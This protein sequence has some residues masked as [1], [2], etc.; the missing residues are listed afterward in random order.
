[1]TCKTKCEIKKIEFLTTSTLKNTAMFG[2]TF[3]YAGQPFSFSRDLSFK[4][5][6]E[7]SNIQGIQKQ[8]CIVLTPCAYQ[9]CR[10][11]HQYKPI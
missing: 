5:G 10:S 11:L 2:L 7:C 9:I 8:H 3:L 6:R 4:L 1:M